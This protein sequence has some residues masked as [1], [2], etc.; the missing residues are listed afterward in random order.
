LGCEADPLSAYA[1]VDG[2]FMTEAPFAPLGPAGF[3][4]VA[5]PPSSA[6]WM[7]RDLVWSVNSS[8]SSRHGSS[9]SNVSTDAVG[10]LVAAANNKT[11][12]W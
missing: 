1:D 8:S 7:I 12:V 3:N 5:L 6:L 4:Y 11:H 2:T 9:S 10:R